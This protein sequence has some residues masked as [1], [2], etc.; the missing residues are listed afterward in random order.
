MIRVPMYTPGKENATRLELRCPV[1]GCGFKKE[2][3]DEPVTGPY[4]VLVTAE[5]T[6]QQAL[7]AANYGQATE[8]GFV[9]FMW[10]TIADRT[11]V[12]CGFSFAVLQ[13]DG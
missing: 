12:N 3:V 2:A 7:T 11:V 4:A 1:K 13:A 10:E 6:P 9:V 8:N 5:R